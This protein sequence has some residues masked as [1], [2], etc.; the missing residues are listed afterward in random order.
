MSPRPACRRL[1][2]VAD[3][4]ACLFLTY[5]LNRPS[6]DETHRNF[7][8]RAQPSMTSLN[9]STSTTRGDDRD[10][11]QFNPTP[12]QTNLHR[13]Y[14]NESHH[15]REPLN[16]PH[17]D[18]QAAFQPSAVSS[19][20]QQAPTIR[21]IK[22]ADYGNPNHSSPQL[23]Q[24]GG[25]AYPPGQYQS[26]PLNDHAT[27]EKSGK[28]GI[29]WGGGERY[30]RNGTKEGKSSQTWI[31]VVRLIILKTRSFV[32]PFGNLIEL[33]L[34][35]NENNQNSVSSR[36]SRP[37]SRS[38]PSSVF[39][40]AFGHM[41]GTGGTGTST[42]RSEWEGFEFNPATAKKEELRYAEGD[43]GRSKFAKGYF[44]LLNKSIVTRWFLYIVPVLVVSADSRQEDT[45]NLGRR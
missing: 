45:S 15:S 28:R 5:D 25:F 8:Y 17:M 3:P 2:H 35:A 19:Q 32:R 43:V 23:R 31:L 9:Q 18:S 21:P 36:G 40:G 4:I 20:S 41:G 13:V 10:R 33:D 29:A 34:S 6:I 38:R 14:T 22:E 39:R 42:P 44:Y 24:G 27:G 7:A 30:S 26:I 11:D 12:S 1:L 16:T 37:Q